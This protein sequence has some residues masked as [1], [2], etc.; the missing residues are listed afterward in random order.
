MK[1]IQSIVIEQV[2][3][4]MNLEYVKELKFSSKRRFRFDYAIKFYK[5]AIEIEGVVS[6]KS[7][8]TTITGY[9]R[10]CEKY[11]LAAI[12][13]WRVLRYTILNYSNIETDLK[14]ILK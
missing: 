1:C 9:S 13:G 14:E 8:H 7:R 10:D 4:N 11:N 6:K 3:K 12:E 5:I 2:L